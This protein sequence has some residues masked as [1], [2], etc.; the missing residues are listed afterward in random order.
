MFI[1][2]ETCWESTIT[3]QSYCNVL[4]KPVSFGLFF[5]CIDRCSEWFSEQQVRLQK[6]TCGNMRGTLLY[7]WRIL[8]LDLHCQKMF[9]LKKLTHGCSWC[10]KGSQ[11]DVSYNCTEPGLCDVS[12]STF[13]EKVCTPEVSSQWQH[14]YIDRGVSCMR[15]LSPVPA[16]KLAQDKAYWCNSAQK[17]RSTLDWWPSG[18]FFGGQYSLF[19][20]SSLTRGMRIDMEWMAQWPCMHWE[21]C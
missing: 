7:E 8:P 1:S 18:Q 13:C 5:N 21:D 9:W 19:R 11:T 17:L 3:T 2:F 12:R 4:S 6:W 10:A 15:K 20:W 14:E 16:T